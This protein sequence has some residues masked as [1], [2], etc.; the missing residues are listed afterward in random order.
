[1]EGVE[2]RRKRKVK[3]GEKEGGQRS[4][5]RIVAERTDAGRKRRKR[6]MREEREVIIKAD[7]AVGRKGRERR[8]EKSQLVRQT[9]TQLDE[10][11]F[12]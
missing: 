2:G 10:P 6:S 1:V 8:K 7:C 4:G 12:G 5:R 11:T 3:G 9:A